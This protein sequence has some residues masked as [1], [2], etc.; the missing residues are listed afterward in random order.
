MKTYE[1]SV[2]PEAEAGIISAFQYIDEGSPENAAKW[3]RALYRAIATLE[4]SPKR[5]ALARESEYFADTFRQL[6]FKSHRIIFRIDE[7]E[8]L[9]RVL[10]VRH[11]SQRTVGEIGDEAL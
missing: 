8:K 1:V 5:C 10:Y 2:A 11:G 6:V 7:S 4:T 9:V 3:L